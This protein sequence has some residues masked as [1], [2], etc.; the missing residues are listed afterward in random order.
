M[1]ATLSHAGNDGAGRTVEGSRYGAI[2]V[3]GNGRNS[4]EKKEG[5]GASSGSKERLG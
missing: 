2:P 5:S 1:R 3:P 4:A